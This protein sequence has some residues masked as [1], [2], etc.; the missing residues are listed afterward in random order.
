MTRALV[1]GSGMA[2][3]GAARRLQERGVKP[4]VVEQQERIGGHT[5][6]HTHDGFTFDEG[7][8]ISFS[9]N[10]RMQGVLAAA[11]KDDYTPLQTY[12]DNYYQGLWIKH[13][14]QINLS[15]LPVEMRVKCIADFIEASQLV[16]P[17]IEHYQDWL[18]CSFGKTFAH[19]FPMAYTQKYHTCRAIDMTTD[20]LGPRLYRPK[21]EEVLTGA[22]TEQT[23]DV[24][25]I[26][27]FRYPNRGGFAAYVE[28]L[29]EGLEVQCNREAVAVDPIGR[30]VK[31]SDGS[32]E[33][34]DQLVS[35]APLPK[36]IERIDGAPQAVRDAVGKLACTKCVVAN[37][38]L[39]RTDISRAHWSY[40]Y[41]ADICFARLSFP[42]MFATD[43]APPD[44]GS[45]QCEIYFSDKYK[46]L[47]VE[48]DEL[49]P[50]ALADLKKCGLVRE[51]D[52]IVYQGAQLLPWANIIFDRDRPEAIA[53]VNAYL[54]EVNIH[55]AGRY[56]MWNYHWTD[57]SYVSG[58]D[59]A[60]A[61]LSAAGSPA[62]T[63]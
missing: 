62:A 10:E 36:L 50:R 48:P 41:D 52:E 57:E 35:T 32:V 27:N 56:G 23:A 55:T 22:M 8:H 15:R 40:F 49:I 51:D 28:G 54:E 19:T 61:A 47:D 31:F 33:A 5:K 26:D 18:E 42:H 46:P 17:K 39:A 63:A 53:T 4:L 43:N 59:A 11:V 29:A 21:L 44:H 30:K 1:I 9:K 13:P 16:N 12:V 24:H 37:F 20:W 34:Y 58:E 3:L 7:P 2:G 14:A 38:G 45:I 25:Y 60:D 6:S